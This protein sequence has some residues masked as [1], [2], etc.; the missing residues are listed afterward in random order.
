[1]LILTDEVEEIKELKMEWL[2]KLEV[3]PE[4]IKSIID[5]EKFVS[6]ERKR[7]DIWFIHIIWRACMYSRSIFSFIQW[8]LHCKQCLLSFIEEIYSF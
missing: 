7:L 4:I 2:N 6:D 5:K 8:F 1:M 3:P